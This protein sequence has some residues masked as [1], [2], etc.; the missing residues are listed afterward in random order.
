MKL[1]ERAH[2]YGQFLSFWAVGTTVLCCSQQP[3]VASKNRD[4]Y[5]NNEVRARALTPKSL[6]F[7]AVGDIQLARGVEKCIQKTSFGSMFEG[8]LPYLQNPDITFGNLECVPAHVGTTLRKS[9]MAFRAHPNVA[10]G[11]RH[12]GFDVVSLANN[13]VND[14]GPLALQEAVDFLKKQHIKPVGAILDPKQLPSHVVLTR[15]GLRIAFLAY[16]EFPKE[17]LK[18]YSSSFGERVSLDIGRAQ[19]E[20][21]LV[22]VSYHWGVEYQDAPTPKQRALARHTIEAGANLIV[23]HHPHVVQGVELIGHAAVAYSLGNFVFD[24]TSSKTTD[25][26]ILDWR[27]DEQGSQTLLFYP[28]KINIGSHGNKECGV[29]PVFGDQA[30]RILNRFK[31]LS[32]AFGTDSRVERS[33]LVIEVPRTRPS[34][35]EKEKR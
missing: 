23:G 34:T 17:R 11:L 27:V 25:S 12:A 7:R 13:H 32:D 4:S 21:D 15:N 29:R 10:L 35:S 6:W 26:L 8:V 14:F 31:K 19:K 1:F 20:S 9:S 16:S 22:V 18:I 5:P 33:T 3:E 24:Q 30:S 28:V 2:I